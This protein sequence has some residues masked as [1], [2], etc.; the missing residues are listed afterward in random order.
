LF[1][2][3]WNWGEVIAQ[4]KYRYVMPANVWV[5]L[6]ADMSENM[7]MPNDLSSGVFKNMIR[8]LVFR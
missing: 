2:E 6:I 7:A 8:R 4:L 1:D 3:K 5:R